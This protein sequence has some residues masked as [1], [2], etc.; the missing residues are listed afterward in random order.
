MQRQIRPQPN[1]R[2]RLGI[3]PATSAATGKGSLA[4]PARGHGR[5][6]A[7][8]GSRAPAPGRRHRRLRGAPRP[9][10][11][12]RSRRTVSRLQSTFLLPA[13]SAVFG[14]CVL[15]PAGK[16]DQA[17]QR[18]GEGLLSAD[19]K[20][21]CLDLAGDEDLHHLD[22]RLSDQRLRLPGSAAARVRMARAGLNTRRPRR[23]RPQLP[24]PILPCPSAAGQGR[25]PP[26]RRWP[27][28]L[29]RRPHAGPRP[30]SDRV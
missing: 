10:A 26:L 29:R 18:K 24:P 19:L 28:R 7:V 20:R 6:K 3:R 25:L 17:L 5:S 16:P 30:R 13:A 14:R 8:S 12:R 23:A 22:E 27:R 9:R 1:E 15:R 21:R 4:P 11:A 2:L